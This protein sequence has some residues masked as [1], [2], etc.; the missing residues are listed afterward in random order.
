MS[1]LA[2][3]MFDPKIPR[4]LRALSLFHVVLPGVLLWM[5]YRFGYDPRGFPAQTLLAWIVLPVTYAVVR[6]TD[7][8]INWVYG[9]GERQTRFAPRLYLALV[10]V[11]SPICIYLPTHLA[12]NALF[13]HG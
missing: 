10:M 13:A 7:E 2:D 6:P 3:Y 5:L 4:F 8:N 1:A 9:W 11:A 12:L